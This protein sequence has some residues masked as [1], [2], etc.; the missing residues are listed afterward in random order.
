[1]K[2]YENVV[3]GNFLYGLGVSVGARLGGNVLPASVNL[4]QQTPEDKALGDVLLSFPGMLR[5]I[6]FKTAANRSDK[7]AARFRKLSHALEGREELKDISH[8]I[9][10][11]VETT[12]DVQSGVKTYFSSYL[13]A[14]SQAA[15]QVE[16]LNLE[17]FIAQTTRSIFS[18][19]TD[20]ENPE[21]VSDYLQL[22]RWCQRVGE[23]SSAGALIVVCDGKGNLRYA[24]LKNIMELSMTH[25]KWIEYR[26]DMERQTELSIE[27]SLDNDIGMDLSR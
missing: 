19:H 24:E 9:H 22:V 1:M 11:Y 27:Q 5:L 12:T 17:R 15:R 6:E 10:W 14:L 25:E 23:K 20:A 4:L 13:S 3:I 16:P 18:S 7:E 21:T 26:Q 2:L 8:R